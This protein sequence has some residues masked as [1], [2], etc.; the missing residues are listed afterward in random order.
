GDT[1]VCL[2]N[3]EHTTCRSERCDTARYLT[4]EPNNLTT[5]QTHGTLRFTCLFPIIDLRFTLTPSKYSSQGAR[6]KITPLQT[7]LV[8]PIPINP[9]SYLHLAT[10]FLT[11]TTTVTRATRIRCNIHEPR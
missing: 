10:P 11:V 8:H 4:D 6:L 5:P 1:D 3:V 9:I 7:I 2:L